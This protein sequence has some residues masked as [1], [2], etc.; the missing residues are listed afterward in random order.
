MLA[1]TPDAIDLARVRASVL[2]ERCG[3][4][5]LF[6]GTVRADDDGPRRVVALEYEAH[7]TMAMHEFE[8]I[9]SDVRA[10]YPGS[11]IAMVHRIGRVHVGEPAV[12]VA[13]AAPHR[14]AAFLGC[15]YAIDELKLHAQIWKKEHFSDGSADWRANDVGGRGR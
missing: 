4:M 12:V 5:V 9:A 6:E 7:M 14:D 13:V 1:I 8:L 2:D 10:R 15:R 3:G 11:R